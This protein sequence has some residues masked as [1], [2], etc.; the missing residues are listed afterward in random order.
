MDDVTDGTLYGAVQSTHACLSTLVSDW[1]LRFKQDPSNVIFHQELLQLIFSACRIRPPFA[2]TF[3]DF[4]ASLVELDTSNV[5][6]MKAKI[7]A[8]F[9]LF[10]TL[11]VPDVIKTMEYS[12][13]LIET[14]VD[15]LTALSSS[16]VRMIR[17]VASTAAYAIGTALVTLLLSYQKHIDTLT[18]QSSNSRKGPMQQKHLKTQLTFYRTRY[19]TGHTL[20]HN[21]FNGIFVHR[22]RD[23]CAEIRH[24]I[25]ND[26]GSLDCHPSCC[27]VERFESQISRLDVE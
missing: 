25:Y 22:F 27:H 5:S 19:E 11:W 6:K 21:L 20:V 4:D 3:E 7:A 13:S 1:L 10:W 17:S 26:S 9:K 18:R 8:N 16:E 15:W 14:I 23:V 24:G 12:L 2:A